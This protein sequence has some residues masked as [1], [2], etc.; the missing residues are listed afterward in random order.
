MINEVIG[1]LNDLYVGS[2]GS[3]AGCHQPATSRQRLALD[4]IRSAVRRFG[5]PPEWLTGP[6]ALEELRVLSD[7]AGESATV[8]PLNFD[9]VNSLSLPAEGAVPVALE[10]LGD[11]AGRTIVDRLHSMMLSSSEGW[12]RV[13]SEGPRKLCGDLVLRSPKLYVQLLRIRERR[14]MID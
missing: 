2:Q 5:K 7:Y 12:A 10:T 9:N 6:G 3:A 8:A 11:G 1:T 13:A 4:C 14:N